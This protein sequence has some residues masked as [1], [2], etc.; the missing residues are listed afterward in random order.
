MKKKRKDAQ[1]EEIKSSPSYQSAKN[2]VDKIQDKD[3][4]D[5]LKNILNMKVEK[6]VQKNNA[7][8]GNVLNFE[9][10]VESVISTHSIP[11]GQ[12]NKDDVKDN[13][14]TSYDYLINHLRDKYQ[15][16]LKDGSTLFNNIYSDNHSNKAELMTLIDELPTGTQ[17]NARGSLRELGQ[18]IVKMRNGIQHTNDRECINANISIG[19]SKR[20]VVMVDLF[21]E[22]DKLC[23]KSAS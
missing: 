14:I 11:T 9:R 4:Q 12:T 2:A 13:I 21:I 22:I 6:S 20:F 3:A 16:T 23:F 7:E 19:N 5:E 18:S 15:Y 17:N 10:V 8:I 1:T